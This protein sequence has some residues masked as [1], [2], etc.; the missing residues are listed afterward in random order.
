MKKRRLRKLTL[1][2]E[3]L[4][5][6]RSEILENIGAAGPPDPHAGSYQNSCT[7]LPTIPVGFCDSQYVTACC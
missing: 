5:T 3:T 2:S 1:Q 4:H 6:L 7:S